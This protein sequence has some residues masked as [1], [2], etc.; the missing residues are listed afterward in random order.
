M[1]WLFGL[2]I[3]VILSICHTFGS[4][5]KMARASDNPNVFSDYFEILTE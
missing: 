4:V 3:H 1:Y 5:V 2:D